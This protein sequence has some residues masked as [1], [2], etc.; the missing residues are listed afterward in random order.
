[1]AEAPVGADDGRFGGRGARPGRDGRG[2]GRA[3][4]RVVAEP[5]QRAPPD[6]GKILGAGGEGEEMGAAGAGL[7]LE[8]GLQ[9]D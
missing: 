4:Y 8:E 6:C 9:G 1:V 7:Q 3:Q 5:R 2:K